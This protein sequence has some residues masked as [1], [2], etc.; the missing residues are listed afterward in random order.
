MDFTIYTFGDVEVFRA[1][2]AGIA[3]IFDPAQNFFSSNSSGTG[4]GSMAGLALLIGLTVTLFAG[5]TAGKIEVGGLVMAA[6]L[7]S[8]MFVPQVGV[9][10]EDYNGAAI[11]RVENVPLGVALPAG[12]VSGVANELNTRMGTAFSTVEG[13]PSGIGTP[14]ALTSP[15]KLLFAMR[16]APMALESAQPRILQNVMNLVAYCLAGRENYKANWSGTGLSGDPVGKLLEDASVVRGVTMY[17][18]VV[19]PGGT[20]TPCSVAAAAIHNDINSLMS[21]HANNSSSIVGIMTAAA[22]KS[23]AAP[24]VVS[25]NTASIQPVNLNLIDDNLSM[26]FTQSAVM[27]EAF[28]KTAMFTPAVNGAFYCAQDSGDPNSWAQ[29]MPFATATLQWQEDSAA[30]GSFFQRLMFHSM[31]A[32]FFMWIC[33]SPVIATIMLMMGNRG[34]KLMSSYLLFGAWAVSWY[35]GA[36]IVNFYML[37]NLEYEIAMLGGLGAVTPATFDVFLDIIMNKIGV[38][39]QMLASVPLLMMSILSGSVYGM[40]QMA[41]RSGGADHYNEKVNT[42]D[43][44]KPGA[45]SDR[46]AKYSTDIGGV[47]RNTTVNEGEGWEMSHFKKWSSGASV[48]QQAQYSQKLSDG[49]NQAFAKTYSGGKNEQFATDLA[50]QLGVENTTDF[51]SALANGRALEW[52][53][54]HSSKF[55]RANYIDDHAGGSFGGGANAGGALSG[56]PTPEVVQGPNGPYTPLN[57]QGGP[58]LVPAKPILSTQLGAQVSVGTTS[59]E[60]VGGET[61]DGSSN[62]HGGA[63][64]ADST[65]STGVTTKDG[66]TWK[67]VSALGAFMEERNS[68]AMSHSLGD[69]HSKIKSLIEAETQSGGT[70]MSSGGA[71]RITAREMANRLS[72]SPDAQEALAKAD[73]MMRGGAYGA[74]YQSAYEDAKREY[75]GAFGKGSV[76]TERLAQLKAVERVA[77]LTNDGSAGRAAANVVRMATGSDATVRTVDTSTKDLGTYGTGLAG[78]APNVKLTSPDDSR[79]KVAARRHV[80]KDVPR[81]K[82]DAKGDMTE[83]ENDGRRK[84][85]ED[86]TKRKAS[87][88]PFSN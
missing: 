69:E 28:V 19:D 35:V 2:L 51:R 47:N 26:L 20:L 46:N 86:D 50:S 37:K 75:G 60:R 82:T 71:T 32:L 10:I 36:S 30:A 80:A 66:L 41:A 24:V 5:V 39:G 53:S 56:K 83:H 7:Y 34:I 77:E 23:G 12:L 55:S 43:L 1:A 33:L 25:G 73:H 18:S 54:Q 88:K 87:I 31:N 62:S 40:V 8:V 76:D 81:D 15:L 44:V 48:Q 59:G 67:Q 6:I 49:L 11:A 68:D 72:G 65:D 74:Q 9:N 3:M 78:N 13:Y 29:C 42:P 63:R 14:G 58:Q 21:G 27:A 45:I 85:K 16:N 22:A 70:E 57:R 38:A 84:A 4:L 61:S 52:A 17:S 79:I 64:R